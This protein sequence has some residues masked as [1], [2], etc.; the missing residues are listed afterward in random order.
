MAFLRTLALGAVLASSAVASPVMAM[1]GST[2][3]VV[4]CGSESCLLISGRRDDDDASVRINGHAVKVEGARLWRARVPVET[5]RAWSAPYARTITV[6][7]AE[8]PHQARLPIGLLGT[9]E[10]LAMLVVRVK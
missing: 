6:S 9:T 2:T 1:G 4:K 3:R 7:V 10:E 5:V 8:V